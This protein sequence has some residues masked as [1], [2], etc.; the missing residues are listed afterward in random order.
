MITQEWI[1]FVNFGIL[2]LG[3]LVATGLN[4]LIRKFF[5]RLLIPTALIAGFVLLPFYLLFFDKMGLTQV[6]LTQITYHFL[7]LSFIAL[8]LKS[9]K[10]EKSTGKSAYKMGIAIFSQYTM[11]ALL[12]LTL[13][14]I[15]IKTFAPDLY[16]AFG[17][18]LPLGFAMGPGQA[19][20]VMNGWSTFGIEGAGNVGLTMGAI[21]FIMCSILGI[22]LLNRGAKRGWISEEEL[23]FSN[24]GRHGYGIYPRHQKKPIGSYN[25]T[26]SEALDSISLHLSLVLVI[27]VL[28]WLLLKGITFLLAK[29]GPL[30]V[31]LGSSLWGIHFIFAVLMAIIFKSIFKLIKIDYIF[32]NLTYNRISGTFVDFMIASA[33]AAIN[34]K[35]VAQFWLPILI[36]AGIGTIAIYISSIYMTS[37]MFTDNRYLRTLLIFGISTG[38][39]STGM[40]LLRTA[41]P[42]FE[43]PVVEDY[44]YASGIVFLLAIPLIL[45]IALPPKTFQT[46]DERYFWIAYGVCVAFFIFTTVNFLIFSGKKA[47]KKGNGLWY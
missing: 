27:Y 20:Q 26:E 32:D 5:N 8:T 9:A 1:P 35:L 29:I 33:I 18:S 42:E 43:S 4:I 41:D 46:G 14:Y 6:K 40:A 12:G 28:A 21:G 19:A 7:A 36:V 11:Q 45:S 34:I 23:A 25:S 15:M 13:T 2:A 31:E 30:G 17:Y 3:L 44:T 39:I 47:F 24:T 10:K 38:T 37:R 16:H 22:I